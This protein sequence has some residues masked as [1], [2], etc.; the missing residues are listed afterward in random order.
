MNRWNAALNVLCVR[1]DAMGDL[2][3]TIP[4]LRALRTSCPG[5]RLTLLASSEGAAIAGLIPELD[6]AMVYQAPWLRAT[7]QRRDA[8]GEYAM[9]ARLR[10]LRFDAAVIFTVFSQNA[11]PAALLCYLAEIPLRLAQ[12]RENP[13]QLLTDWVRDSDTPAHARHEVQRQLDLVKAVGAHTRDDSLSLFLPPRIKAE[14]RRRIAGAGI[15]L[16]RPWLLIHPG[17]T[18]ASRRY[19]PQ[20]YAE[21]ARRLALGDA[22]QVL[23]TGGAAE[24]ELVE[25]IRAAMG[26][27]SASLAGATDAHTLAAVIAAAPLLICNNTGPAHIA[28]AVGTPVVDLYAQT[29]LQHAPWQVPHRLLW[30]DVP[31]KNCQRSVCPEGHHRCLSEVRP[32]AVVAAARDLLGTGRGREALMQG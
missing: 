15:D 27:P 6:A 7:P 1:L 10:R 24:V 2:L 29:N 25:A 5:R 19:P 11:L 30:H 8:G 31:C 20:H 28:A 3:M 17:A 13:Y 22:M 14:A 32:E 16:G 23:F 9:A 4:A 12:C 18:A 21:T 26:A